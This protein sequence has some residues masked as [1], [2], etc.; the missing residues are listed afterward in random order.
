MTA[1]AG[2]LDGGASRSESRGT[3]H[4]QSQIEKMPSDYPIPAILPVMEFPLM[5]GEMGGRRR[6]LQHVR[7][8]EKCLGEV[9]FLLFL[10]RRRVLVLTG[11]C[12]R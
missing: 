7:K 1:C 11:V 8:R 10:L 3:A 6:L 9:C 2:S 4:T 5:P 12:I